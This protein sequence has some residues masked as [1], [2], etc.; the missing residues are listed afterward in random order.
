MREVRDYF[1]GYYIEYL[2]NDYRSSFILPTIYC[3]DGYEIDVTTD[4]EYVNMVCETNIKEALEDTIFKLSGFSE[5]KNILEI[6]EIVETHGGLEEDIGMLEL[7]LFD[8]FVR[9]VKDDSD[10]MVF[11]GCG[12]KAKELWNKTRDKLLD[13][14]YDN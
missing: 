3:K 8:R 11:Y 1:L 2:D 5:E 7:F 6:E 12:E 13:F 14:L 9:D 4:D 10:E